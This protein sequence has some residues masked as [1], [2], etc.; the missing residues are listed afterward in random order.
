MNIFE[1][2]CLIKL[3]TSVWEGRINL[4]SHDIQVDADKELIRATKYLVDRDC[5][6]P[7][8]QIRHKAR[9]VLY[10]KTLPFPIKR[11]LFIPKD[12]LSEVDTILKQ[13]QQLFYARTA[14]F[15]RHFDLFQSAVKGRLDHLYNPMD[16]P[17]DIGSRFSFSWQFFVIDAP[18][19]SGVLSPEIYRRE[20]ENFQKTM[21]EFQSMAVT[22]LRT[23]FAELVDHMVDRLSGEKKVFRDSM[24]DHITTFL[25]DF[26]KLNINHDEALSLQVERCRSVISGVEAEALRSNDLFRAALADKMETIQEALDRMMVPRPK[27]KLRF[28]TQEEP[29]SDREGAPH[30]DCVPC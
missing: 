26:E 3:D 9:K 4:P 30:E 7:I 10:G 12:I 21:A 18:G 29:T 15:E 6:K 20:K 27:R 14:Y 28:N 2:G 11:V 19:Q 13:F 1:S 22:T 25:T 24:I 16:Y 17:A 8:K 5:L 23:R